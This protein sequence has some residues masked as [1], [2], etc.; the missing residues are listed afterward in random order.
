ML[1]SYSQLYNVMC[2]PEPKS[3]FAILHIP[4][5]KERLNK[6]DMNINSNSLDY[7]NPSLFLKTWIKYLK[8]DPI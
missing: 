2:K 8:M 6:S 5:S 1:I 7:N 3:V 4:Y